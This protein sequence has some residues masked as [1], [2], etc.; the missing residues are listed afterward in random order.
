MWISDALLADSFNRFCQHRRH[1][2]SVPGPLEAQRRAAKRK[3][4]SLAPA[5]HGGVSID[6]SILLGSKSKIEWWQ[7]PADVQEKPGKTA[8]PN[9]SEIFANN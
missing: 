3:N 6:P 9:S 7:S 8:I 5:A 1:G 2:S 4:T